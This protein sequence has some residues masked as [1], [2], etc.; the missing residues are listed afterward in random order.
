MKR[1]L[2]Y[3]ILSVLLM[4]GLKAQVF[5][6]NNLYFAD[7]Y[8]LNPAAALSVQNF[9]ATLNSNLSNA[10]FQEAPKTL[11]VML[12]GALSEKTGIG[13]KV[14]TDTRGAFRNNKV[15][16]SY[17]YKVRL[18]ESELNL[19]LSMGVFTQKFDMAG[20]DAQDMEDRVLQT[21]YYNKYYFMNVIGI[22]YRWNNL[23]VGVSAPNVLQLYNHYMGYATYKYA[24]PTLPDLELYPMVLY[25][26]LPEYKSQLDGGIKIQY[27]YVWASYLYRTNNDMLAAL[28]I[29]YS[30]Y[31]LGY[32]F[33]WNNKE[34]STVALG[35]HEIVLSYEFNLSFT[36]RKASYDKNKM[37]WQE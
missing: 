35:T 23:N 3:I 12:S 32:S 33:G 17:A 30:R 26:H 24:I 36:P 1:T 29:R 4:A 8:T 37:P 15:L 18:S 21:D 25:Q 22:D 6:R 9:R 13:L 27:Q 19:G 14:T 10:G 11:G 7:Y 2:S 5:N 16:G 34:F 31:K 28:G 20:I